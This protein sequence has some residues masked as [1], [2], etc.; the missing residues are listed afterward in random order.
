MESLSTQF[1]PGN[2]QISYGLAHGAIQI[3]DD[4]ASWLRRAK[5]EEVGAYD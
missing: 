5:L 2:R 3:D 4:I 1:L